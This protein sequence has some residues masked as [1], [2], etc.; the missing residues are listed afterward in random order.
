MI[1]NNNQ[2]I[3]SLLT[4]IKVINSIEVYPCD[5]ED[6]YYIVG[7]QKNFYRSPHIIK[8][9]QFLNG[10]I[11]HEDYLP[12]II[13]FLKKRGIP[14]KCYGLL[15]YMDKKFVKIVPS[16]SNNEVNEIKISSKL[17]VDLLEKTFIGGESFRINQSIDKKD[18]YYIA[19]SERDEF[20]N[21]ELV[22]NELNKKGIPY[23]KV[24][25]LRDILIYIDSAFIN[26][27]K[28][29]NKIDEIKTI[30]TRFDED[31]A[32]R[33]INDLKKI[34]KNIKKDYYKKEDRICAE[35]VIKFENNRKLRLEYP[36]GIE[37]FC[38]HDPPDRIYVINKKINESK[39][40]YYMMDRWIHWGNDYNELVK[41]IIS[42]FSDKPLQEIKILQ[43]VNEDFAEKLYAYL[44]PHIKDLKIGYK[45]Y[46]NKNV[47]N[48]YVE[49]ILKNSPN[50]T[51]RFMCFK[52][53]PG[54]ELGAYQIIVE[55]ST[56]SHTVEIEHTY[57]QFLEII[58]KG[59]TDNL[60][61]PRMFREI[62]TLKDDFPLVI[63]LEDIYTWRYKG[64]NKAID[65]FVKPNYA[66]DG[67]QWKNYLVK[68]PYGGMKEWHIFPINYFEKKYQDNYWHDHDIITTD[69][70]DLP[71]KIIQ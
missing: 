26:N 60:F 23:E 47:S 66:I 59:Y 51:F 62:K 38:K 44:K 33:L 11:L 39:D 69:L 28:D 65:G 27:E 56:S 53:I 54:V 64:G 37:V 12:E 10:F 71:R 15:Y 16:P 22:E 17:N 13:Q 52:N 41:I 48:Y 31:F 57:A 6:S 61:K 18:K 25:S 29:N 8:S 67:F 9:I 21:L 30:N 40:F 58:L 4:E 5:E 7:L 20:K 35:V 49:A 36:N 14:V 70:I 2:Y 63:K 24:E 3:K 19:F 46:P 68:L 43:T 32:D 1:P 55:D 45:V 50:L 42:Q 34:Y